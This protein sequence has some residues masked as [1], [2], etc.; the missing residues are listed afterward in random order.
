MSAQRVE[1]QIYVGENDRGSCRMLQIIKGAIDR[2]S[3]GFIPLEFWFQSL[4]SMED[5]GKLAYGLH[6]NY[7]HCIVFTSS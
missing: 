2:N 5:Y 3:T 4:R 1:Q 6:I 7:V